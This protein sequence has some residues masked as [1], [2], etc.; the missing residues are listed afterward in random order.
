MRTPNDHGT[1]DPKEEIS[2]LPPDQLDREDVILPD[3]EPVDGIPT[4]P[5]L[6]PEPGHDINP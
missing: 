3:P 5:G 4:D 2:R 1:D 6:P